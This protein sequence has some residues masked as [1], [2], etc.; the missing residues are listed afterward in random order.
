MARALCLPLPLGTRFSP[1]HR[2]AIVLSSGHA[3]PGRWLAASPAAS[4]P[5]TLRLRLLLRRTA[6]RVAWLRR[7]VAAW[8]RHSCPWDCGRGRPPRAVASLRCQRSL[9]GMHPGVLPIPRGAQVCAAFAH[10][11]ML[12]G[13]ETFTCAGKRL[14]QSIR[15]RPRVHGRARVPSSRRPGSPGWP[16]GGMGGRQR[17]RGGPGRQWRRCPWGQNGAYHG[18]LGG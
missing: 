9:G 2:G 15:P 10:Y 18:R 8:G 13:G 14:R 3:Q 6:M 4:T 11:K 7:A 1:L 16:S 12:S 5:L 17:S